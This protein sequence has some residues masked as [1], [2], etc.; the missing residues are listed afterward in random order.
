M[1]LVQPVTLSGQHVRLEPLSAT[2]HDDLV[3]AVQD[4]ELW[5]HWY[6]AIPRPET[7]QAEI[8]RR[9]DLQTKGSMCAFA[10]IDPT[11][12]RA[13]GMTTYMNIDAANRRVEIGSTWYRQSVQRSPLN[14][15]AKRLLLA[16]AFEKINCIAVEFRTHF[17]N[18]QSRRAIERL[19]AK[20]DGVLRSHQINP[21][22]MAPG[23]LRDTCVYSIIA[24]EW[25]NV[26]AHL[27]YQLSRARG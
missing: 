10:V 15:E 27:D 1:A 13:V 22:P 23:A 24:S 5:N 20:L 11:T 12:G 19:G 8:A 3:L 14:T 4:G 2:H 6:T 9:L 16:H 17:F 21:H 25:P 7:M 18:Q 26:K